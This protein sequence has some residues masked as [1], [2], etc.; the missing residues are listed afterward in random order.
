MMNNPEFIKMAQQMMGNM[1]GQ[2]GAGM[3]DMSK[4]QDLMKDPSLSKLIDNPEALQSVLSM[5]K[6][7]MAKP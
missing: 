6:N 4:M 1:G 7:P 3:P 2:G 5:I